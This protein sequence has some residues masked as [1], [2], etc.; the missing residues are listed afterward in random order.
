MTALIKVNP[1]LPA[2][3]QRLALV[4]A[5]EAASEL[6]GGVT[7]GFPIISYKGK[8]WAVRKGGET[9]YFTD[10]NGNAVP[11]I[12][13]VIVRSNPLPSKIFYEKAYAEGTNEAPRCFSNDGVTPDKSVQNPISKSCAACPNNVWGSKITENQKK[14]KACAD[15][16]R[17]AVVSADELAE[18]G[19]DAALH[20][21]RV[22]AASLNPVK[23]YA[24]KVLA[25]K[26]IPFFGVVTTIGF[27]VAVA[28]PQFTLK[29]KRFVN[30]AEATAVETLR[31]S[32]D[33]RRILAEANEFPAGA[34]GDG[35]AE[36]PAPATVAGG[37]PT[38]APAATTAP[39]ANKPPKMRAATE[40][41]AGLAAVLGNGAASPPPAAA[42]P[43]T[44]PAAKKPAKPKPAAPPPAAAPPAVV[45]E[46]EGAEPE[47]NTAALAKGAP[48]GFENLLDSILNS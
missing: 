36:D 13:V 40:E 8:T 19:A 6:S 20:L 23:D 44:P 5:K 24:E 41:E 26:G 31:D 29:P 12:D 14:T 9:E 25:P 22:P 48:D 37:T 34:A 43:A 21:L 7:S 1:S 15:A 32:E 10:A 16:R 17:M 11:S 33:A 45:E 27:E 42:A 28:H 46:E 38:A 4:A 30:D 18:K 47:A 39:V 2:H 3:L 35:P